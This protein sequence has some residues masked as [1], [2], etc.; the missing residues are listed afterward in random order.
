MYC[1]GVPLP[2]IC[3]GYE[4]TTDAEKSCKL[5]FSPIK[6]DKLGSTSCVVKEVI[7]PD[8]DIYKQF[9]L[10]SVNKDPAGN[11]IYPKVR[12]IKM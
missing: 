4:F 10:P 9:I 3:Y 1:T 7:D 8:A 11:I 5:W 2:A 6:G 12:Y